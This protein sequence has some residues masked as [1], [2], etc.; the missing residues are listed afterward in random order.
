MKEIR[1]PKCNKLLLKADYLKGEI[2]CERCKDIVKINI[3]KD[4]A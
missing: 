4:R 3:Q 2:K 1:C